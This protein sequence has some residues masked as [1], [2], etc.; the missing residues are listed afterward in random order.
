M[1]SEP[2]AS[3][4]W[5]TEQRHPASLDLDMLGTADIVATIVAADAAVPLAVAAVADRI[6]AAADLM[7]TALAAGGCV[8]YLGAGTSG[9][10]G[11]LDAVELWPTFRVTPEQVRAHLAGGPDAMTG[12]VEGAE[13]DSDAGAAAIADAGPR[14]VI[15]GIAASGRTPYVRGALAAARERGL[16]TVL[17]SINPRAPLAALADVAI[18]PDTGPEVLTGSTRMKAGTAQKLVL[19]TLSTATMVRLG[20]TFGNLMV[21]MVATNEKLHARSAH[22][23][24]Q[25]TGCAPD[26]AA[27]ALHAA[28]GEVRVA[29][30]SLLARVDAAR[31]AAA[32]AGNPPDPTRDGD[33]SGVRAAVRAAGSAGAHAHPEGPDD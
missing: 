10:L 5:S 28:G 1:T 17:V 3:L 27:A 33:P 14:D 24:E 13:D 19:N 20:K 7:V 9:R 29:I 31:A 2:P 4:D 32:L 18:L 12:A 26:A 25:A 30:V 22:M 8:H 15:V 16:P 6:A 23:V 21:D 11:V